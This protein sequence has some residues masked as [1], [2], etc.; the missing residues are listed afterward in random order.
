MIIASEVL[1]AETRSSSSFTASLKD[2]V[3]GDF[4]LCGVSIT[5]TCTSGAVN[6]TETGFV[7][8]FN[9]VITSEGFGTIRDVTVTDDNGTPGN[10][11]DDF[12]VTLGSTSI[13]KGGTL[14]YS[15]T[16]ELLLT[17]QPM[18]SK[19]LRLQP[20]VVMQP[21]QMKTA[22]C[23]GVNREPKIDVTSRLVQP[24]CWLK[25]VNWSLK[26]NMK[27]VSVTEPAV[28]PDLIQSLE[29]CIRSG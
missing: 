6:A 1:W 18:V 3:L 5:K 17:H 19:W 25:T 28:L 2:F 26:L 20:L 11:A 22:L 7:Y 16:F 29:Q 21:S 9:G 12:L 4:E 24:K 23:P 10:T 8:E 27:A 14:N 13:P 15:G